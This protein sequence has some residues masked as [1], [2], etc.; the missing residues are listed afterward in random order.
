MAGNVAANAVYRAQ[1]EDAREM[2]FG[3]ITNSF[4]QI[5]TTFT[6]S[7]SVVFV[8]NN[9]NQIIDF[10]ISYVDSVSVRFSLT[11]GGSLCTDMIANSVQ[12]AQGE[13]AWC[14]YRDVAPTA[15]FVQVSALTPV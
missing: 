9:T 1:F 11:P 12:I 5:G 2:A 10:C 4:T 8:Q 6:S 14:K 13:A 15:G 7:F 3:D